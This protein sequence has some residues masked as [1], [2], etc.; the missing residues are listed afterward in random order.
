[1]SASPWMKFY[2]QDWRA[3]EKL[4]LCSLAARGLWIEMLALMHRSER[5]GHLV[6]NGSVPTHEQLAVQAGALPSEVTALLAELDG[7]GVFSRASS[8]SIYSRRMTRDAKKA[9]IA[10][11]NGKEGGNPSLCKG[12]GNRASVKGSDKAN[13]KGQDKAQR[14]EARG[15]V[16]KSTGA[17]APPNEDKALFDRGVVVLAVSGLSER[18]ARAMTAKWRNRYGVG[19]AREVLEAAAD[20]D[21]P[22]TYAQRLLAEPNDGGLDTLMASVDLKYPMRATG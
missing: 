1:M 17:R 21:N 5:Y 3:D 11:Q 4:R 8:G 19:R 12:K 15:S 6:I 2:P 13:L 9:K 16:D 22:L 10:R 18:E 20:K 14:P 7:A